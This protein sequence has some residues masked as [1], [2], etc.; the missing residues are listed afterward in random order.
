MWIPTKKWVRID[1][2]ADGYILVA[3]E[4]E[5]FEFNISNRHSFEQNLL[6]RIT[7]ERD[8]YSEYTMKNFDKN[9]KICVRIDLK[10]SD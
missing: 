6:D 5:I 8:N 2:A 3:L 9:G 4:N 1:E 7:F 10:V